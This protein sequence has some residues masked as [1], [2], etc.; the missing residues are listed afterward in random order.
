MR[1]LLPGWF[2]TAWGR[3]VHDLL[4]AERADARR[5]GRLARVRFGIATFADLVRAA[6]QTRGAGAAGWRGDIRIATRLL[7]RSPGFTSVAALSLAIGVA[8]NA[9]AFSVL[10]PALFRPLPWPHADRLVSVRVQESPAQRGFFPTYGQFRAWQSQPTPSVEALLAYQ[11]RWIRRDVPGGVERN[12][13][14]LNVQTVSDAFLSLLGVEL[15]MGRGFVDADYRVDAA[16]VIL[17][18]HQY[19]QRD[20]GGRPDI[21]GAVARLNGLE[22][23]VVGVVSPEFRFETFDIDAFRPMVPGTASEPGDDDFLRV[24]VRRRGGAGL[25]QVAAE[26]ASVLPRTAGDGGAPPASPVVL[27]EPIREHLYGWAWTNFGPFAGVAIFLL[28]LVVANLANLTLVR[29]TDR[30]QELALRTALGAGRWRIA[31]LVALETLLLTL[32]AGGAGILLAHW[33][34]AVLVRLDPNRVSHMAPAFDTRVAVFAAGVALISGALAAFWP[35]FAVM[36]G[37]ASEALRQG[38]QHGT[39]MPRQRFAQRVLV[40]CQIVCALVV[41][42]GAGLLTRTLLRMQQYDPGISTTN[43]LTAYI[44]LPADRYPGATSGAVLEQLLER[45]RTTPAVAAA[46]VLL[47]DVLTEEGSVTIEAG[48]GRFQPVL[49]P[50]SINSP[51][52]RVQYVSAGYF[53]AVRLPVIRGRSLAAAQAEGLDAVAVVNEEA[54]RRW[55]RTAPVIGSRLR[56]AR[57]GDPGTWATV[58]GVVPTTG[59]TTVEALAWQTAARVYRPLRQAAAGANPYLYVR[60][61]GDPLSVLPMLHQAVLQVDPEIRIESPSDARANME[62]EIA[63]HRVSADIL[64]ALAA[65]G[66]LLAT[67]GI[68]GVTAYAVARRTREIGIRKALGAR[69]GHVI[70]AIGRESAMLAVVGIAVGLGLAAGVTRVLESM[71]YGTSPLDPTVFAV[72]SLVIALIVA[73]ATYLPTRRAL[74]VDPARTLR[75]E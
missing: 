67:M 70:R 31:R 32:V 75:S 14:D 9:T 30:R 53:E 64:I 12:D 43:L 73:I 17:V 5:R 69:T 27:L 18:S 50:R 48:D 71:L 22:H 36:R 6:W 57:A 33:T 56:V 39:D 2:L 41:V 46:G 38:L 21:V 52:D 45:V 15:A 49:M 63:F 65:F 66:L 72:A 61:S 37:D 62:A 51:G 25:E 7:R 59:W 47:N 16:P 34:I 40:V 10:D 3:E 44:D 35:A 19:W 42:T 60:T 26:L 29:A 24:I 54:A 13:D 28:L 4:E 74:R 55:W 20:L 58:I 1:R 68:Y 23:T 11:L 8:V